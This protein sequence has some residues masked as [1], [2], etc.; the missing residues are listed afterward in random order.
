MA[1]SSD[2]ACDISRTIVLAWLC[3]DFGIL[4]NTFPDLWNQ[5]ICSFVPGYTFRNAFQ[6]P[7]APSAV[8]TS[9]GR[10]PEVRGRSGNG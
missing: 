1:F 2:G 5:Q 3:T 9:A 4:S 6:N 8:A 7:S 10:A